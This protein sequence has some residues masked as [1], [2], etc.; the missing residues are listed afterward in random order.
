MARVMSKVIHSHCSGLP[1]QADIE[2]RIYKLLFLDVGLMN[3]I[4]GLNWR[5]IS[6]LDA[7]INTGKSL[8]TIRYPFISLPLYLVEQLGTIIRQ[9]GHA[10]G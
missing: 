5:T 2:E 7:K 10:G 3:A 6:Q 1:L 4:C 8:K 9:Q